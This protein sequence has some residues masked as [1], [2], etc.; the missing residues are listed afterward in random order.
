MPTYEHPCKS[1]GVHTILLRTSI[2]DAG[3]C[4]GKFGKL[5]AV[6]FT[7]QGLVVATLLDVVNL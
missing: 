6:L 2:Y 4:V 1:L 5:D 3:A 7:Q